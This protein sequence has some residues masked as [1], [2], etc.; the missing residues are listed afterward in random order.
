MRPIPTM[1]SRLP[2][3]RWPSIQVGELQRAPLAVAGQDLRSFGQPPRPREDHAMVMSAVSSVRDAGCV[4]HGDA[5]CTRSPHRYCRRR[6]RNWDELQSSPDWLS[7][8]GRCGRSPVRHDDVARSWPPRPAGLAHRLV[9][10]IEARIE[11]FRRMTHFSHRLS[12]SL[13]R[14]T[15]TS[16][17]LPDA[18]FDCLDTQTGVQ[19][20]L[21]RPAKAAPAACRVRPFR[22]L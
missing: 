21:E 15:T 7:T 10:A 11:Q 14:W 17:F 8:D 3:I 2:Q 12:G 5:A 4:G 20:C 6:C 18:M 1:P 16:G 22:S 9:V 13:R 19:F